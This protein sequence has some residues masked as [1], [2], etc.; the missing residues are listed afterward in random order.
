[1]KTSLTSESIQAITAHLQPAQQAF[2]ARY[3]GDSSQRQ[4]IHVVYGGAHL[5]KFDTAVRLGKM[6]LAS[7]EEYAPDF[8]HLA[9]AA[10]LPHAEEVPNSIAHNADLMALLKDA[11]ETIKAKYP[12]TWFAWTVYERVKEKL[13][14]EPIEDYRIDFE[15][16]YGYRSDAQE[17][18]HA[19]AAAIE[20]AKGMQANT[21][22]PFIGI[23]IKP[24]TAEAQA[25]AIRTFDLF[26]STLLEQTGGQLPPNFVVMLPKVSLPEQ[27]AAL[28]ELFELF[29]QQTGLTSGSLKMEMMIETTQAIINERGEI[30]LPH[31]LAAARGRC[32]SAH[33][34]AY[35]YTASCNVTAT[36]QH[37]LHPAC[38]FARNIMQV[39][40]AGTGVWLSDGATNV[41]PIP[42]HRALEG[43][44]LTEEQLAENQTVVHRAW[45]V[46]YDHIQHSL[47][48]AFYQGW[49]LHPAQL[50]VRYAA[51]YAFFLEG[52]DT[53]A[54]RLRNFVA[55]AA[56]ATRVGE[57]FDDA[58]TGQG[59][60]NYF[61]RAM[62]CGALTEQEAT[63]FTGLSLE[64]LRA[65][66]FA[67]IL[68]NRQT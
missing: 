11:P 61:L 68:Q 8:A 67:K 22:P 60:L 26:V 16:G 1:M 24:F 37:M 32:I 51:V 64:E 46:H 4:P 43:H 29:E 40:L 56:Q 33:F 34:G 57:M 25:R 13:H 9:H 65:G 2:A 21:L 12:A 52:L 58:A 20:L 45:R 50:P 10:G 42:P 23:R 59:L 18:S 5:F 19:I 14:R 38:D 36:H 49:D 54:A 47:I 15:D 48:N 53:A 62:N 7:L 27:V 39:A 66:S 63:E 3:P 30:N 35:D 31:L 44:A 6:A 41:M 28:V 17:D 55:K